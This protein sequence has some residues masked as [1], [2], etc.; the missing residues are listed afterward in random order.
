MRILYVSP[1]PLTRPSAT[2]RY[3]GALLREAAR[4][5]QVAL[6][7]AVTAGEAAV[8]RPLQL[9]VEA[10]TTLE[11]GNA[12]VDFPVPTMQSPPE[13][14]DSFDALGE[15]QLDAYLELLEGGLLR[16]VQHVRPDVIHVNYLWLAAAMARSV[17]PTTP[18]V[19]SCHAIDFVLARRCAPLL[20]RVIPPARELQRVLV[21]TTD[22]ARAAG[23]LYGIRSDRLVVA[24]RGVD[25]AAFRPPETT[26]GAAFQRAVERHQ[27]DLPVHTALRIVY[28]GPATGTFIDALLG[29]ANELCGRADGAQLICA[30]ETSDAEAVA[31]VRARVASDSAVHVLALSSRPALAALLRGSHVL[32]LG[33]RD[34]ELLELSL[35]A[36]ACGCRVVVADEAAPAGWPPEGLAGPEE[37][38][39]VA[40]GGAL[41]AVDRRTALTAALRAHLERARLG[42]PDAMAVRVAS[43]WSWESVFRAIEQIYGACRG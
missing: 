38:T 36:L 28:V 18:V 10:H 16:A 31:A 37:F 43:R 22:D 21:A 9:A 1:Q 12:P 33:T 11:F 42:R 19:A 2:E 15:R 5:Q 30:L 29:A 35:E 32:A 41:E 24:G 27:L 40:L 13:A 17:F 23:A 3:F 8:S 4:G 39:R 25:T 7:Q 14:A 20:R 26:T 6:L 34:D